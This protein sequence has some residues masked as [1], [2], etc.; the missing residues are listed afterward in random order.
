MS[1]D[2]P[3]RAPGGDAVTGWTCPGCDRRV[4]RDELPA[5]LAECDAVDLDVFGT[6]ASSGRAGMH[7]RRGTGGRAID[8]RAL[9]REVA[10]LRARVYRVEEELWGN[11]PPDAAATVSSTPEI[12]IQACDA[13]GIVLWRYGQDGTRDCPHCTHGV[14]RV[15]A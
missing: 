8:D 12:R 15:V 1:T 7:V 14:L 13:C 6:D 3:I 4:N 5:H 2:G 11:A 10:R 9:R